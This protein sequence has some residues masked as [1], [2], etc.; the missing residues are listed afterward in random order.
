MTSVSMLG[1]GWLGKP[2]G[3]LLVKNGFSVSGSTTTKDKLDDLRAKGIAPFLLQF[4]PRLQGSDKERFFTGD[5][6]IITIPPRRKEGEPSL[7]L[8]QIRHVVD[9]AQKGSIRKIIFISSTS[10]YREENKIVIEEDADDASLLA[11]AENIIRANTSFKSTIVRFGGLVG[12][13]RHPGRFLSGKSN[14]KGGAAPVNIIHQEDCIGIISTIIENDVWGKVFNACASIRVSRKEFYEHTSKALGMP[15]PEFNNEAAKFKIV[16]S[17]KL[18]RELNYK[19][20]YDDPMKM[21]S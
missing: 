3:E 5:I 11:K 19:F 18:K 4:T 10:V 2:L 16:N 17:D 20:I 21:F 14:L 1:C 13:G 15:L 8:E 6:L 9:E 7:Y 12:P